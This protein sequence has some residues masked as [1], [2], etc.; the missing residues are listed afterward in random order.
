MVH[1]STV[2][3]T[4]AHQSAAHSPCSRSTMLRPVLTQTGR[5]IS[6]NTHLDIYETSGP[7]IPMGEDAKKQY[8]TV[9]GEGLTIHG[10]KH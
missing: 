3:M 4:W 6:V 9:T 1:Q 2:C 7:M 8:V 5:F 10:W